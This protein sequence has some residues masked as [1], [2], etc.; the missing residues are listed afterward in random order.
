[1]CHDLI[2]HT[3]KPQISA[4]PCFPAFCADTFHKPGFKMQAKIL[5]HLFGIVGGDTIKAPLWD[6]AA[7][8]PTAYPSN[9]AY[10]HEYV[11]KLLTTSF[12]NMRPQQVVVRGPSPPP[13][14]PPSS[15][16]PLLQLFFSHPPFSPI[17]SLSSFSLIL[18][19]SLF[20]PD[21]IRVMIYVSMVPAASFLHCLR[22][23][24][25]SSIANRQCTRGAA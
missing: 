17:S 11:T 21:S 2:D 25:S 8:G 18:R 13:P 19:F 23:L 3:F 4:N 24:H 5:H 14:P 9:A 6:A 15:I 12:P 10:V 16:S 7:A 22:P 20:P 1:M